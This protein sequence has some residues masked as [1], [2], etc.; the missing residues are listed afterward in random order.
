MS[1]ESPPPPEQRIAEALEGVNDNLRGLLRRLDAGSPPDEYLPVERDPFKSY[2]RLDRRQPSRLS[3]MTFFRQW[4][5]LLEAF[6]RVPAEFVTFNGPNPVVD[7]PCDPRRTVE[8]P[9]TTLVE[10]PGCDRSYFGLPT[11]VLVTYRSKDAD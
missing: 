6:K 8:V 10:C 1:S 2:D 3:W 9:L 5:Y 4:P 11:H 7:C